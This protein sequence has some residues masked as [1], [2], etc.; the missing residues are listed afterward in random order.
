MLPQLVEM[1]EN[2]L[3]I[4]IFTATLLQK[5]LGKGHHLYI[6]NYYHSIPLAKYFLQNNNYVTRAIRETRKHFLPE[7]KRVTLNRGGSAYFEHDDII[8]MRCRA[9]KSSGNAN[10]VH[11]LTTAHKPL[12]TNSSKSD[13]DGNIIQKQSCIIDYTYNMGGVDVVDQQLDSIEVLRNSYNWYKK[14]FLRLFMQC[15]LTSEKPYRN[16]GGKDEFLIYILDL[17]TLL[18]LFRKIFNR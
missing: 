5:Y 17:I 4:D 10:I 18:L 12:Q 7:L 15:V 14:L 8:V 9:H 2:A 1:E 3:T 16:Q 6:D 11:L 13:R